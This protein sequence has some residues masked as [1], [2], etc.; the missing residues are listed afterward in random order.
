MGAFALCSDCDLTDEERQ[1][2][3]EIFS[4]MGTVLWVPEHL[5]DAVCGVSGSG[6]AYVAMFIEAMADGGVREGLPRRTAY[7]LAAQTVLGTAQMYLELD[8]EP[9]QIKDMVTS[10]AGTTIEGCYALEKNGFRGAV[11]DAVYAGAK[12]S[13][14]LGNKKEMRR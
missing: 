13:R 1:I 3:D 4:C 9:A 10:P 2:A 8:L 14:E 12:R 6:P 11:M 7:Q 5:I